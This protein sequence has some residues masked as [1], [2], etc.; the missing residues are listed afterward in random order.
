MS[1]QTSWLEH[2]RRTSDIDGFRLIAHHDLGGNGDGFQ[3]IR[4]D[5]LLYIAHLGTSPA[6]L[7]ILDITDLDRPQ[8]VYQ[9]EH[10]ENTRCHKVQVAGNVLI[11]NNERPY[12]VQDTAT[13]AT[14]GLSVFDLT[15]P[16]E[17]RQVGFH[18]ADGEGTHRLW[19]SELPYAHISH[20]LP[21]GRTQSYDIVDLSDPTDPISA[22]SWSVPGTFAAD[23]ES[24][25]RGHPQEQEGVHGVI[26]HGDRA[27]VSC[28]DA[29][30]AI[31]DISE[32]AAPTLVSRISWSPPFGGFVHTALPLPDRGL[33]I[34]TSEG[35]PHQLQAGDKRIWV[36]DVRDETH[37]VTIATLPEPVPPTS[38]G[39]TSFAQLPGVYGPHNLHE[40]RPGSLIDDRTV[41]ATYSNAGLRVWDIT[42]QFQPREVAHFVPPAPQGQESSLL[43]DLYVDEHGVV[44]VTDRAGGGV[45]ILQ[46]EGRLP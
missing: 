24:W 7:T 17:P 25:W 38:T 29:G 34:A 23:D 3:V 10:P 8:L 30:M 42:N 40:N 11:Q 5:D 9:R 36:I 44:F 15:D 13:A 26:P 37:P 20:T 4:R 21:G 27:Y 31:L 45:Y 41:F 32:I 2:A 43:N 22:G 19:L 6:A 16:A 18:P 28:F 33:V 39:A 35:V 14:T 1:P 46:Y 12:W